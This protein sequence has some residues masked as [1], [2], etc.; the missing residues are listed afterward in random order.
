MEYDIWAHDICIIRDKFRI[1]CH[2]ISCDLLQ[3]D[4]QGTDYSGTT[5]PGSQARPV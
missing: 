3:N 4:V 2:I 1:I 5:Y